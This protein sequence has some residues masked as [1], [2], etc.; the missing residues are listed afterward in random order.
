[1][2][3][4]EIKNMTAIGVKIMDWAKRFLRVAAKD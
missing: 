1:M 2:L 4:P 3:G